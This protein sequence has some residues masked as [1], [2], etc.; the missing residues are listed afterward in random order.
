MLKDLWVLTLQLHTSALGSMQ[1][2]VNSESTL[3]KSSP[4]VRIEPPL[5]PSAPL[6]SFHSYCVFCSSSPLTASLL[7]TLEIIQQHTPLLA[8]LAP[9]SHHNTAAINHLPRVPL[10]IQHAQTRPLAQLLSI[11]HFDE[12]DLVLGAQC[13]DEFLVRFF[14]AGFVEDAHVRLAAVEGFGGFAEAARQTVVD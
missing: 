6:T 3:L 9:V 5:L 12:G 7:L 2:Q 8:L 14:F 11:R 13:D 4:G 10:S 1:V